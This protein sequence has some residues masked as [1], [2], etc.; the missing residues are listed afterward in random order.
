MC[1]G[2]SFSHKLAQQHILTEDKHVYCFNLG[3]FLS[4]QSYFM[5][6]YYHHHEEQLSVIQ[7]IKLIIGL[8]RGICILMRHSAMGPL[9]AEMLS[10]CELTGL[11]RK[12]P[13]LIVLSLETHYPVSMLQYVSTRKAPMASQGNW[14]CFVRAVTIY[15]TLEVMPNKSKALT[16]NL[17]I[18]LTTIFIYITLFVYKDATVYV[19]QHELLQSLLY[20]LYRWHS[21]QM[22]TNSS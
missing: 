3:F 21:L 10:C 13:G 2:K 7:G 12:P 18:I 15:S 4:L 19:N 22:V 9:Q 5:V 16:F 1:T 20:P 11:E 14:L 17:T 6:C 8:I